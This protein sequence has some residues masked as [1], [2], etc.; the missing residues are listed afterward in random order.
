M[1]NSGESDSGKSGQQLNYTETASTRLTGQTYERFVQYTNQ[2][3]IGKS[4]GLR[5]LVRS[6]LEDEL[7]EGGNTEAGD[8]VALYDLSLI[9]GGVGLILAVTGDPAEWVGPAAVGL[10]VIGAYY[11]WSDG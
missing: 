7:E 1:G 9:L 10:V 8:D 11:R 4:E 5:R 6:G 3:D 2:E